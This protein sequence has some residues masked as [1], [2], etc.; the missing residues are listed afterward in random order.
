MTGKSLEVEPQ[1]ALR[2]PLPA[3]DFPL[4]VI[5]GRLV[6]IGLTAAVE[7]LA[8]AGRAI[9]QERKTLETA[10]AQAPGSR[11]RGAR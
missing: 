5:D 7:R 10:T 3:S 8:R 1:S 11:R 4:Q 6:I 9:A 2:R